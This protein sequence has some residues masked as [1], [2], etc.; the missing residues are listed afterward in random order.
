V[1][2]DLGLGDDHQPLHGHSGAGTPGEEERGDVG[3]RPAGSDVVIVLD[4]D[5]V[6]E[7]P[8]ILRPRQ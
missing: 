1:P 8:D 4:V 3:V 5:G 2:G 6:A 7:R